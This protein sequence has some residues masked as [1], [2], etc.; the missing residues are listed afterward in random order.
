MNEKADWDG[1]REENLSNRYSAPEPSSPKY[2]SSPKSSSYEP[3]KRRDGSRTPHEEGTV[4]KSDVSPSPQAAVVQTTGI[5]ENLLLR[6]INTSED[7][8]QQAAAATRYPHKK[9]FRYGGEPQQISPD[10]MADHT[11][12]Q[13]QQL[14]QRHLPLTSVANNGIH[15]PYPTI[16]RPGANPRNFMYVNQGLA[17]MF[18]PAHFG[19]YSY[20]LPSSVHSQMPSP[21]NPI[22]PKVPDYPHRPEMGVAP[23]GSKHPPFDP[24]SAIGAPIPSDEQR[25]DDCLPGSRG[26]RSLPYPLKKKDGRM[27][28]ECNICYKTFG[29]LSNLKV[30]LRTHSGERPFKCT[31]CSKTFTQLAHL[32]KHHLVHTGEK[33]HQCDICKKR[34][35]STSNLKTH[36]RLHSGQKPY[37]C[38]LCQAKFTQFV[39]LKLH[40][41]LHTN[42]R[43]YTCHTC[44]KKYISASGLRTHWKTTSCKPNA[45]QEEQMERTGLPGYDDQCRSP[46]SLSSS[47][48][49]SVDDLHSLPESERDVDSCDSPPTETS[50]HNHNE[51]IDVEH[52]HRAGVPAV[53]LLAAPIT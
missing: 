10:S 28:Y 15:V 17:Q 40:K 1:S 42:E 46:T 19:M 13:Q 29:Q 48:R 3:E 5:L 4:R 2:A 6:R 35:S 45:V 32:Q 25:E 22:Y 52:I 47:S 31:A 36:L 7:V 53:G 11:H 24:S 27:H 16:A 38:D 30:H 44:T 33:P 37:S 39:H 14:Q 43:P 23:P 9:A 50:H 18:T 21:P 41:R 49:V 26:Y 8:D 20:G 12:Q 34:F 51:Y